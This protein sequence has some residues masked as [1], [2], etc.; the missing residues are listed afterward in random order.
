VAGP[1]NQL[2][3]CGSLNSSP[4]DEP[5]A[6]ALV[7]TLAP[8]CERCL[9]CESTEE[10]YSVLC[11]RMSQFSCIGRFPKSAEDVDSYTKKTAADL[12]LIRE[13]QSGQEL[14]RDTQ[15]ERS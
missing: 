13:W 4:Q 7:R 6:S 14:A 15:G 8:D 2:I 3:A 5:M 9:S 10:C 11:W 12:N 1:I